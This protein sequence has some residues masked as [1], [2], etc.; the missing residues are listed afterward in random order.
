MR[1]A[2]LFALVLVVAV[3]ALAQ[4]KMEMP[5]GI[6]AELISQLMFAQSRLLDLEGAFPQKDFTWR[7]AEGVRSVSEA[8]LH[9]AGSNYLTLKACGYKVPAGVGDDWENDSWEKMTT[10]KAKIADVIKK[11]FDAI[12]EGVK[13]MPE[14][15]FDRQISMFG[16]DFTIRNFMIS[17]IAHLHEHLGQEIA[18]ARMNGVVPPWTAK[19]QMQQK[20]MKEKEMKEK[21]MKQ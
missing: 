16:M 6:R 19:Q 2:L 18:Y 3:P 8:F 17:M 5:R 1:R 15:D 9:A 4:E 14:K 12:I 10:D 20:A 7:P 11:S 21:A 13:T